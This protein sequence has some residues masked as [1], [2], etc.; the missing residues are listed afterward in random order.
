MDHW[1]PCSVFAGAGLTHKFQSLLKNLFISP[2]LT[3]LTCK[4]FTKYGFTPYFKC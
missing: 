1:L 4:C 3:R 2:K